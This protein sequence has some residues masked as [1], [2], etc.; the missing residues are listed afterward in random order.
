ML[1]LI[2][3]CGMY[4]LQNNIL[5]RDSEGVVHQITMEEILTLEDKVLREKTRTSRITFFGG[6][7][8]SGYNKIFNAYAGIYRDTIDR[9]TEIKES[10]KFEELYKKVSLAFSDKNLIVFTHMPM[11]CWSKCVDYHKNYIY[12]SGHT[13]RNFFYDDGDIR[14]YADNQ[15]GYKNN[16]IHMKWFD[17]E[18]DYDYFED[19]QDGIYE[20]TGQE[21]K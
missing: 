2:D 14:L 16:K 17:T 3:E 13:H 12:V 5:Y 7:A 21:Y 8:F 10:K 15:I 11:N 20:I 18:N 6:L 9:T 4:L 19:Y 1:D